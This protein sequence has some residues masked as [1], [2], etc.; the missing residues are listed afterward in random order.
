MQTS[1][2]YLSLDPGQVTS[3]METTASYDSPIILY[4]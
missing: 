4:F 1:F 3:D 2:S